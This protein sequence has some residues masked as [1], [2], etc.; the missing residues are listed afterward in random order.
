AG[1]PLPEP[2]TL[3]EAPPPELSLELASILPELPPDPPPLEPPLPGAGEPA[4]PHP[5]PHAFK[6]N[7]PIP[8][9]TILVLEL[10]AMSNFASAPLAQRGEVRK[11]PSRV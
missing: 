2:P 1:L 9:M 3:P 7:I 8:T 4:L 5:A 11:D 6:A 10:M